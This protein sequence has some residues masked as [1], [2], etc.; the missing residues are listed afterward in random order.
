MTST[1]QKA[2]IHIKYGNTEESFCGSPE[3]AWK[4][5]NKFFNNLLPT[6]EIAKKLCL[7]VDLEKL[8]EDCKGLIAFSPEGANL[9]VP[10]NKLTDNE[11]LLLWLVASYLGHET[12]I[13]PTD[14]LSKETLQTKLGKTSKI[15]STRLGELTKN[16]S[17]SRV[18]DDKF[19]IT[20]FGINQ[21]QK[22]I[23]SHIKLRVTS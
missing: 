19:R 20:T 18:E 23:I 1:P 16:G 3:E 2:V 14:S 17:I 12:G 15:T 4:F 21:I 10:K 22:D 5:V 9:L 11:T 7:N 13:I 6:F 8:A